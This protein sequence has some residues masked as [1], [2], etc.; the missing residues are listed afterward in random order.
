[1]S[2]S[3]TVQA[4][5]I[6]AVKY[7]VSTTVKALQ[8]NESS[9]SQQTNMIYFFHR[10]DCLSPKEC[11]SLPRQCCWP[12]WYHVKQNACCVV[13][14]GAL[15]CCNRASGEQWSFIQLNLIGLKTINYLFS[16]N[17]FSLLC[18]IC[19]RIIKYSIHCYWVVV[20][21]IKRLTIRLTADCILA[22]GMHECEQ[23]FASIWGSALDY[24]TVQR[25]TPPSP[26]LDS[27]PKKD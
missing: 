16:A 20:H 22:T 11:S 27:S 3:H 2:R 24:C 13:N 10:G 19:D 4:V 1:M 9:L 21:A 8:L 26:A 25:C 5:F 6:C 17:N 12:N 15:V 14:F 23:S 7:F 18:V